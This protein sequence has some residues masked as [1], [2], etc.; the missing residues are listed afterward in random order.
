MGSDN[1]STHLTIGPTSQHQYPPFAVTAFSD[2]HLPRLIGRDDRS[3][4]VSSRPASTT[5]APGATALAKFGARSKLKKA[6]ELGV[7][8]VNEPEW[9]RIVGQA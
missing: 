2:A 8:V 6:A 3:A 9:A 1:A 4:C 7:R 5:L